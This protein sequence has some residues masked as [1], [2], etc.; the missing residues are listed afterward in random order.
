[1]SEIDRRSHLDTREDSPSGNRALVVIDLGSE[2]YSFEGKIRD[3]LFE[4]TTEDN[5]VR[6]SDG[7]TIPP[8]PL[9]HTLTVHFDGEVI[10]RRVSKDEC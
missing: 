7:A 10:E 5:D 9:G 3:C 2:V 4:V 8:Y 6:W 1:M